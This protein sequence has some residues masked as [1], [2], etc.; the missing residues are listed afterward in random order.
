MQNS[1]KS[2]IVVFIWAIS[3]RLSEKSEFVKFVSSFSKPCPAM[4]SCK[5]DDVL[6]KN[7]LQCGDFQQK[8]QQVL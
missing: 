7:I 6:H 3:Y 5:T 8:S 2:C 1:I 4:L